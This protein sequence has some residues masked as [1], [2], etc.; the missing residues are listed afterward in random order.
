M[1]L[2]NPLTLSITANPEWQ[3]LAFYAVGAAVLLI[4]LFNIPYVG[5]VLR[6]IFSFA[7]LAF[8]LFILFQ[9]A[10]F[11][12]NLSRLTSSLGLGGQQVSGGEVRIPLSP[13]GHFWAQ[14]RINGV[15]RRMLVDSGA[16][17]T[18][19]SRST[20]AEASVEPTANMIPVMMHTANGTV[21]A[22]TGLVDRLQL[23]S[24]EARNLDVVISPALGN[25]DVLGMNFLSQLASWRVENRTLILVPPSPEADA[26]TE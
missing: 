19:L 9:Q 7:V 26:K 20:A 25:F 10:P 13:D 11:D 23:G 17:V 14:A 8:C 15:E 24:I 6:A 21:E 4:V 1:P 18:A 5:R 12:P 2:I 16:T 3:Q 22:E